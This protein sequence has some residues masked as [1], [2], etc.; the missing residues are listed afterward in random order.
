[1]PRA[2]PHV[3][4]GQRAA[5]CG[6]V[7]AGVHFVR[8]CAI[9][10]VAPA[11]MKAALP[12]IWG[13]KPPQ[14]PRARQYQS[15]RGTRLEELRLAYADHSIEVSEISARFGIDR[16]YLYRVAVNNGW[17]RRARRA[18]V[19]TMALTPEQRKLFEKFRRNDIPRDVALAEACR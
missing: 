10:G 7:L 17:P 19:V 2:I 11:A 3:T 18:R 8:A 5:V 6:L 9:A 16:T 14:R 4:K 15:W 12:E 13:T 1:M